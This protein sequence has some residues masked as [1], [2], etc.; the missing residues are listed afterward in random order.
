MV[1]IKPDVMQVQESAG[2]ISLGGEVEQ[3]H[4][5]VVFQGEISLVFLKQTHDFDISSIGGVVCGSISLKI[6]LIQ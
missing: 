4:S 3:G 2:S 1:D 5:L 6:R